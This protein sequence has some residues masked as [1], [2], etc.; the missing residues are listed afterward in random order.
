MRP[1]ESA[2]ALTTNIQTSV[3][4]DLGIAIV[5]SGRIGS[6]RARLVKQHPSLK[7]LAVSDLDPAKADALKDTVGADFAS[8]S[9]EEII[10]RP[11]VNAVIVSS[12]EGEHTLPI[13]LALEM[14]K[15]VLVEKPLALSLK[16]ADDTLETLSMTNGNL[17]VG[18]SRRF[19]DVFLRGKEQIV[20]GRLGRV[21]GALGRVYNGQ[22]QAFAILKRDPHATPVL[23]VLTYYVDLV[24]WFLEGT[25]PVEVVARG[26]RKSGVFREAG[27]DIDDVT[28]AIVTY[29]DGAVVNF[30]IS[31]ALPRD[32]PSLGQSDRV[33]VLGTEGVM[34]LDDDHT[35]QIMYSEKGFPHVYVPGHTVNMVFLGSST[36]G[37]W[38]LGGFWGPL[39]T[40]TRAWLDHVATGQPCA[41]ATPEQARLNLETTIAIE[42]AARTGETVRLPLSY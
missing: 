10:T 3:M 23:D 42:Q 19:K 15:T 1:R 12:S 11:E 24:N 21:T 36:P 2:K 33:E 35:D 14:G 7:F 28:W 30:G 17:R 8:G 16:E 34:L 41:L 4:T 38:A 9:N 40:E 27:Y 37:D 32:Y 5:G 25:H 13:R 18:Y 20:Q 6:L 39:A 26:Y 22:S 29:A 31:Y